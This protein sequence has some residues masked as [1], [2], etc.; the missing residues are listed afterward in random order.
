MLHT[1]TF[2]FRACYCLI[3]WFTSLSHSFARRSRLGLSLARRKG[4]FAHASKSAQLMSNHGHQPPGSPPYPRPLPPLP[5]SAIPIPPHHRSSQQYD[6]E[7]YPPD[8]FPNPYDLQVS[9][10]SAPHLP[11]PYDNQSYEQ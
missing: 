11:L 9:P 10:P 3:V 8:Q 2:N 5:P 7:Y 6:P 4:A 1:W